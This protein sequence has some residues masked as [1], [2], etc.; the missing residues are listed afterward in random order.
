MTF[1]RRIL[2]AL[3]ALAAVLPLFVRDQYVLHIAI[4]VLFFAVL[5]SSL[6]LVVGYVGEFSLG[7]T[8]FLGTGAYTAAILA[9]Q[10]GW[11]LWATI[12]M[13]GLLAALM[14]VVIGALTLRLQGPFFVIVTLSFAEVLRL[15]ADNWIGLT[16][17]PMGIAGVPQPEWLAQASNLAAKHFYYGIAW[18]LLALTLYLSYRFV[19]SNAGRAAV[20]VRENRYVA[21]SIGIRPLNYTMLALVLGALL[22]GMAGGFYA[23]YISFVGPEVFRFA[24]MVSMI[25]MVLIGGKGT[26][27]GPLIG[28]L[29]VTFLEEYLREAKELRLSIFGLAVIAIV[30]FL[31]RGLM[32]FITQRREAR[33]TA[34]AAATASAPTTQRRPA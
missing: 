17:G 26:L 19:Y 33:G 25:I 21:Q 10:H 16:N 15:I 11:P 13:A 22:S 20:A 12:P 32:G 14:G 7:H 3:M 18:V 24:F 6:N 34:P 4:M 29:L 30:L 9:T 8:A 27:V 5:A 23:H 2:L 31:P 28:A 1:E